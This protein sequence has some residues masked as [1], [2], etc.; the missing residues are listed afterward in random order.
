MWDEDVAS[1]VMT[2][3]E[4]ENQPYYTDFYSGMV[5][6]LFGVVYV[7]THRLQRV[8]MYVRGVIY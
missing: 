7:Y 8:Y 3:F 6:F 2:V 4:K 5:G 1:P